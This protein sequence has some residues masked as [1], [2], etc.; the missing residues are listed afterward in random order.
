MML[1][2]T[3]FLLNEPPGETSVDP[4]DFQ[5]RTSSPFG[6]RADSMPCLPKTRPKVVEEKAAKETKQEQ[7]VEQQQQSEQQPQRTE[8]KAKMRRASSLKAPRAASG[9]HEGGRKLSVRCEWFC[10]D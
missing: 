3:C 7:S 5:Q 10:L 4:E 2:S 9:S 1:F 6:M 8:K